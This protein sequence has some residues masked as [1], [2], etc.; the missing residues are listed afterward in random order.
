MFEEI[1]QKFNLKFEDL[2]PDERATLN[3]WMSVLNKDGLTVDGIK[4][5]VNQMKDS[6]EA[7]LSVTTNSSKQDTFLKARLR[8]YLLLAS[9]L[10]GPK[11]AKESMERA[12]SGIATKK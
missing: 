7:E 2:L 10:E 8:N 4:Q 11:K 12:L 1:L 9:F 6:V 3:Q 5:Y